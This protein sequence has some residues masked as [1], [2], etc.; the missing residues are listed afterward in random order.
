MPLQNHILPLTGGLMAQNQADASLLESLRESGDYR[1]LAELLPTTWKNAPE[2]NFEPIRLRLLASEL[3]IRADKTDELK[4]TLAPYL[5]DVDKTPFALAA[6]VLLGC[7]NYHLYCKNYRHALSVATQAEA[8][9][10]ARDDEW[11]QAEALHLKA[12]ALNSLERWNEALKE[13]ESAILLYTEQARIYRLGLAHLSLGL[14]LTR[15][16]GVEE[17]HAALKKSVKLLSKCQDD[18]SLAQARLHLAKS[19][20]LLGEPAPAYQQLLL[21]HEIFE[22][23][24]T[25]FDYLTLNEI[26]ATLISL[27][28]Y[29]EAQY[30]ICRALKSCESVSIICASAFEVKAE[31]HIA[32]RECAEAREALNQSLEIATQIK[33]RLQEAQSKRTLGKLFLLGKHQQA[34]ANILEQALDI[35]CDLKEPLLVLEI[36]A[37]MAQAICEANPTEALHLLS[38]VEA[39]LEG[40]E[41]MN[42]KR[43]AQEARKQIHALEQEHFFVLSDARLPQLSDARDAMLKWMWARSLFQAKGNAARAASIIGVTP[44]YIRKLTKEIPRDLLRPKKKRQKKN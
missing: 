1:K 13:I 23:T 38:E 7:A 37:L 34:A 39:A 4:I 2:Y 42:L 27:K 18:H 3:A 40:R 21:A 15:V 8:A 22:K 43:M 14:M 25:N 31:F 30:F 44:T 33:D 11:T 5:N 12:Q 24:G 28:D 9:A 35:A 26:A 10:R 17:A 29:D 6:R 36:K 19:L 32:R 20:N 16:G 41:L